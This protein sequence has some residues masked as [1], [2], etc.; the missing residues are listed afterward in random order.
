MPPLLPLGAQDKR[1]SP[2]LEVVYDIHSE[3]LLVEIESSDFKT[4]FF[5]LVEQERYYIRQVFPFATSPPMCS[6]CSSV[7]HRSISKESGG[8]LFCFRSHPLILFLSVKWYEDEIK[9][10]G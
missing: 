7:S 5:Y 9:G 3:K 10:K 4:R 1:N 2:S 8:P 6:V